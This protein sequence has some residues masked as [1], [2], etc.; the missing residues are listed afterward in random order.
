MSRYGPV[1][2]IPV[3]LAPSVNLTTD[4]TMYL[5]EWVQRPDR[6]PG[7]RIGTSRSLLSLSRRI[8][9]GLL[10]EQSAQSTGKLAERFVEHRTN[11]A[12]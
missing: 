11:G 2:K 12:K 5:Q 9:Q 10:A 1:T 6:V 4:I 3:H 7:L 8:L